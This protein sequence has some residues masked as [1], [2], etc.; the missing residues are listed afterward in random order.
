MSA[1]QYQRT[2]DDAED[3]A[4]ADEIEQEIRDALSAGDSYTM[5][6]KRGVTVI[7]YDDVVKWM[8]RLGPTDFNVAVGRLDMGALKRLREIAITHVICEAPILGA[9]EYEREQKQ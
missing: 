9:I 8:T 2:L 4:R 6:T 1:S 3:E 5:Q 7:N